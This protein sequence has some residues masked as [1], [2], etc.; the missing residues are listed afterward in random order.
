MFV[1]RTRALA[2]LVTNVGAVLGANAI[3]LLLDLIP[4][5]RRKRS[6]ITFGLLIVLQAIMWSSGIAWQV[7]FKR[8]EP[9]EGLGMDWTGG[10]TPGILCLL[11]GYYF[12]DAMY[13]GLAYYIMS[14]I[15]SDAFRL[16]RMTGYYKGVQSAGAAVSFGMDAA[17]TPYLTEIIV[18]FSMIMATFVTTF[19]VIY[20]THCT[21]EEKEHK[22][23][24][25]VWDLPAGMEHR[26]SVPHG[27]E[28][29]LARA[30]SRGK[31]SDFDKDV[32]HRERHA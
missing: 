8:G 20:S 22:P 30:Q 3:G 10:K 17:K 26:L 7:Q 6:L 14:S 32:E 18:I 9:A 4:G 16:A 28:G 12:V 11:L 31:D 2:S 15:T 23:E 25:H 27:H 21:D 19:P 24:L 5:N 29:D 13:Q 1:P